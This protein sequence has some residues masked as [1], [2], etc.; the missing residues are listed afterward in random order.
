MSRAARVK[1]GQEER[2]EVTDDN[3][4]RTLEELKY[5]NMQQT[6]KVVD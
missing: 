4:D 2:S 6:G 3:E 5:L 1:K